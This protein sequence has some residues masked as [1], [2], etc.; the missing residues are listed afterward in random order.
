[1]VRRVGHST[2]VALLVAARKDSGVAGY[3]VEGQQRVTSGNY[4]QVVTVTT[5]YSK[6]RQKWRKV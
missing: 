6:N 5:G 3:K 1:M 2:A 4:T